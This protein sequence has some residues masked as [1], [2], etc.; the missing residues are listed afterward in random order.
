MP[1]TVTMIEDKEF[2]INFRGYDQVKWMIPGS[3]L[4]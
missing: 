3:D 2:K 4:R 1:I